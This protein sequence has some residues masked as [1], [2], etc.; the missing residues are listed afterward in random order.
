MYANE[1]HVPLG[2]YRRIYEDRCRPV[3]TFG[4]KRSRAHKIVRHTRW[5]SNTWQKEVIR[6]K[7]RM[8]VAKLCLN[9]KWN[10]VT[11]MIQD[12]IAG[13]PH[14]YV[15][16]KHS[17]DSP[18]ASLTSLT[19]D[20]SCH[21][22]RRKINPRPPVSLQDTLT[23]GCSFV[24]QRR[25]CTS[26]GRVRG[27]VWLPLITIFECWSRSTVS[28]KTIGWCWELYGQ[29]GGGQVILCDW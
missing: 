28:T 14:V 1:L 4:L 27:A 12:T 8:G 6:A 29:G 21:N 10:E 13:R 15:H 26:R 24:Y 9:R 18:A 5:M 19:D 11:G 3:V 20:N 16:G 2:W 7:E 17:K 22:A 23:F 25:A